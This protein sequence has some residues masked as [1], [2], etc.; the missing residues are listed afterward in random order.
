MTLKPGTKLGRYEIRSKIGEGGMGEVYLALDSELDRTVAIK[1]LPEALA[2]DKQPTVSPDSKPVAYF[3][4]DENSPWRIAVSPFEGGEPLKTFDLPT[5]FDPPLHWTTD[6]RAV[7]YVDT[8]GGVSN[9]VAQPLDGGA[10]KQL[11][12]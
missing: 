10:V 5:T 4:R 7:A 11:T 12:D 8:R 9:L 6:G 2:S 3:Y 1:I